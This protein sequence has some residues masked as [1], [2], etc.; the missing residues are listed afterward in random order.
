MWPN[1]EN[2]VQAG[3][4][5]EA[6]QGAASFWC[7]AAPAVSSHCALWKQNLLSLSDYQICTISQWD[8]E[9]CMVLAS[10]HQQ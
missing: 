8:N 6:I 5:V 10:T 1:P 9:H 2:R 3:R 7:R 4:K